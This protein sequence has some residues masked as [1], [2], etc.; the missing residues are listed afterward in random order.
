MMTRISVYVWLHNKCLHR[1]Y[2]MWNIQRPVV[3]IAQ[4]CD[5]QLVIWYLVTTVKAIITAYT[6]NFKLHGHH[7][8]LREQRQIQSTGDLYLLKLRYEFEIISSCG[9]VLITKCI[10]MIQS[11]HVNAVEVD[12]RQYIC[13]LLFL[14]HLCECPEIRFLDIWRHIVSYLEWNLLTNE[15][16]CRTFKRQISYMKNVSNIVAS[17]SSWR[18]CR[19]SG[20]LQSFCIAKFFIEN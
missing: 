10:C 14:C 15:I 2:H 7:C 9:K 1:V 17:N 4:A 13:V 19:H 18:F 5:W 16:V 20:V 6:D 8:P 11:H 12:I 3:C